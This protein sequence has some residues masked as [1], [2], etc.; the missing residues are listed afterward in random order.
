MPCTTILVGKNASHDG[1]TIIARNDDGQFEAKRLLS[2]PGPGRR[3]P[4]TRR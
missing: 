2:H 3:L 4:P 1:S